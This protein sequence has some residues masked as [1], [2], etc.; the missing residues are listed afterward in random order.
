MWPL[1]IG[2]PSRV[3]PSCVVQALD[4]TPSSFQLLDQCC[5]GAEFDK[6]LEDVPDQLGLALVRHQ[7]PVL[8]VVAQRRHAA[9]PHV[10]AFSGR[11]LVA[12]ALAGHLAFELDAGQQMFS[13]SRPMEVAELICWVTTMKL[14]PRRSKR[15]S[16]RVS[17]SIL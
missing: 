13:I 11:E 9:H 4:V 12:D 10:F 14:T 8:D 7:P 1:S 3:L 16:E 5:A 15:S 2:L 6:A 17:R